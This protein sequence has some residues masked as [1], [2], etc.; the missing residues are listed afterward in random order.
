MM[1]DKGFA[2]QDEGSYVFS[3]RFW[4]ADPTFVSGSQY[5]YGPVFEALGE[6]IPLL[7]LLR[8]VMVIGVNAWFAH[9]FLRWLVERR[10]KALPASRT[11]LLLLLT[12]GGGMSYLWAPLTPGYYDLTGDL[13]LALAALMFHA[14]VGGAR[15]RAWAATLSG[16][17]GVALVITKWTTPPELVVVAVVVVVGLKGRTRYLVQ[18]ALGIVVGLIAFQLYAVPV[19]S[20]FSSIQTVSKLTAV[21]NHSPSALV[22]EMISTSAAF[23]FMTAVLGA[24]MWFALA[25]LRV[26][27]RRNRTL[28]RP[29]VPICAAITA[30]LGVV[31][32]W[33]GIASPTNLMVAVALAGLVAAV[34]ASRVVAAHAPAR[35]AEEWRVMGAL[36]LLPILQT[37]GTNVPQIWIAYEC[38]AMWMA[39]GV[40]AAQRAAPNR[41]RSEVPLVGLALTVVTTTLIAGT[42]TLTSPFRTAAWDSPTVEVLSLG[43]RVAPTQAR[44]WAALS[45]AVSPYVVARTTPILTLDEKAGLAY[46]LGGTPAGSTWTDKYTKSRTAGIVALT[47]RKGDLTQP[48][49]LVID[50]AIDPELADALHGCGFPYPSG[51]RP[52]DVPGGPPGVRVLVPRG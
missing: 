24:P 19:G 18:M 27:L 23:L 10:G 16:V 34:V 37:L 12:A 22:G 26:S 50:R 43:V 28:A 14:L 49:V 2:L 29:V 41:L 52:L 15:A 42:V 13:T 8:L 36:L 45:H 33:Q 9:A 48:P 46:L 20:F 40:M 39:V 5:F 3:Y 51:Y 17:I 7:R 35:S 30:A 32:G 21:S 38:L 25:G 6:S 44:Q 11:A 1:L 47:C 31:F 4:R